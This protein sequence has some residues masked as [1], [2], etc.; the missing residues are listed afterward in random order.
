MWGKVDDSNGKHTS[1]S[2][3]DN[4]LLKFHRLVVAQDGTDY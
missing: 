1:P 4:D 2:H 3:V